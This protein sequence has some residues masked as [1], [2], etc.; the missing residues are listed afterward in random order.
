MGKT[1]PAK[2]HKC[3]ELDESSP[4]DFGHGKQENAIV[5]EVQEQGKHSLKLRIIAF[6]FLLS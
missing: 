1:N 4:K 2:E 5:G 6:F 3:K